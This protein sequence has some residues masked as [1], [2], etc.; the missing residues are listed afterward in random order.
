M[1]KPRRGAATAPG[2]PSRPASAAPRGRPR[3]TPEELRDR[4][5]AYCSRYGVRLNDAG[6]PPFSAGKRETAQHREW[7]ALYKAHRRLSD[8][9]PGA[10][11]LDQRQQLLAAQRGR[12]VVCHDPLDLADARCDTGRATAD[13]VL[14]RSCL[15][16]VERARSLGPEA[17]DRAKARL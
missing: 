12:C 14:H 6:L 1:A 13:A 5:A 7:M 16:F 4:L 11:D 17:L 3:L 2:S 15:Q 10:A 9:G 8:R